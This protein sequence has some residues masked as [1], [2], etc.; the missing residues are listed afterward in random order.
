MASPIIAQL[1][2]AS[3]ASGYID[4]NVRNIYKMD[5]LVEVVTSGALSSI[6]LYDGF[7]GPETTN[8][9][10]AVPY[11]TGVNAHGTTGVMW[12]LGGSAYNLSG[13]FSNRQTVAVG[14]QR[15]LTSD[16]LSVGIPTTTATT[17]VNI[18]GR[19]S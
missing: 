1:T 8:D 17:Q 9:T 19:I 16:W 15:N 14:I 7:G 12:D 18:Y 4:F 5:I 10:N 2:L 13:L 3:G 6:T 11:T